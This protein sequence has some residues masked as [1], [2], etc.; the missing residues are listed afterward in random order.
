[1]PTTKVFKNG[2]SQAVRIPKEYQ[3][4]E[5]EVH[6][7]KIGSTRII[8][9]VSDVWATVRRAIEEMPEDFMQDGRE[10]PKMQERDGLGELF[11]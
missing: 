3:F 6:I 8:T 5:D 1:M 2:N 7:N 10:Q 9:P 11:S 4:D